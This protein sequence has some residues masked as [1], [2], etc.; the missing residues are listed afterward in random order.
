MPK[1]ANILL[2]S[3]IKFQIWFRPN[4]IN[5]AYNITRIFEFLFLSFCNMYSFR[6]SII[7]SGE[8]SIPLT[9]TYLR[10][11]CFIFISLRAVLHQK[12]VNARR[13]N[14][15]LSRA[16]ARFSYVNLLS[17]SFSRTLFLNIQLMQIFKGRQ[18]VF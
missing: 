4:T 14:F 5:I 13:F 9:S 11:S 6:T 16:L 10:I 3:L 12:T 17:H 7:S 8:F 2:L 1:Y 18:T 15:H